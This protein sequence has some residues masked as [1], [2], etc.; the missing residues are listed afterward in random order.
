MS[1]KFQLEMKDQSIYNQNDNVS[2]VGIEYNR[3]IAN[4]FKERNV[5]IVK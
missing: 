5:E 3:N 2:S 1:I 4:C